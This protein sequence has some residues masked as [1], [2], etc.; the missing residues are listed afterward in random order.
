MVVRIG[1]LMQIGY[2]DAHPGADPSKRNF[3]NFTHIRKNFMQLSV[4]ISY[5]FVK[6]ES[7]QNFA[8]VYKP[9]LAYFTSIVQKIGTK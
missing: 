2:C 5:K 1:R 9:N 7:Y 4:K 6:N 3:S 8:N